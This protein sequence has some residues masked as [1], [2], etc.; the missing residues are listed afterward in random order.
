MYPRV[1]SS[2]SVSC[3]ESTRRGGARARPRRDS[4][5]KGKVPAP[6]P[7]RVCSNGRLVST[8]TAGRAGR[9]NSAYQ[10]PR[11]A[12]PSYLFSAER[13]LRRLGRVGALKALKDA[14]ALRHAF[15][16]SVWQYCSQLF[17]VAP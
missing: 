4:N 12:G 6:A 5:W 2:L 8:P 14:L 9:F 15:A 7:F 13:Q 11:R 1:V 16:Q 10:R 17:R 3:T